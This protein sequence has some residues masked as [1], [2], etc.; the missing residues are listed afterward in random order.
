MCHN[1]SSQAFKES[2]ALMVSKC[3]D[4]A[5]TRYWMDRPEREGLVGASVASLVWR[6]SNCPCVQ[7]E[8]VRHTD[9]RSTV[10]SSVR[11]SRRSRF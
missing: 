11:V 4:Y 1:V 2:T 3:K 7:R 10:L 6:V 9:L 8:R 5:A